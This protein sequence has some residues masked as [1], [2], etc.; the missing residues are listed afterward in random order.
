VP[1][2][3]FLPFYAILR[4]IPNKMGGVIAMGGALVVLLMLPFFPNSRIQSSTFKPGFRVIYWL[5]IANFFIL[6]WIGQKAV[7]TPFIEVGQVATACDFFFFFVIIPMY[8]NFENI[9]ISFFM[10]KVNKVL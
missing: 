5:F 4:S 10:T 6:G 1:E 8:T 9:I 7:E 3:Y 2:W